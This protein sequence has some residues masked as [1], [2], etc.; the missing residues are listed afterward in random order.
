MTELNRCPYCGGGA[1][2][3]LNR[4]GN[5]YLSEIYCLD[6]YSDSKVKKCKVMPHVVMSANI[7]EEAEKAAI[8]AWNGREGYWNPVNPDKEGRYLV[9]FAY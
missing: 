6:K 4:K 1:G 5:V 3:T 7:A 9:K 2:K 8:D